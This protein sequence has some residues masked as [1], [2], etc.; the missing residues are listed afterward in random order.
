MGIR[1]ASMQYVARRL[2][3]LLLLAFSV[4]WQPCSAELADG[5]AELCLSCH[6]YPGL[7]RQ[8]ENNT[9]KI[10][11][12]D[13]DK[14]RASS[15]GQLACRECHLGV[16]QIP[17][18][19]Q[20]RTDC[21]SQCHQQ[22][23]ALLDA[24]PRKAFHKGQ[25]S[26]VVSLEDQTS[27]KVCHQIYP[28]KKE[29]FLRAFL[30]MH[31]GYL[32]CEVCHLK[33][34]DFGVVRY[35]WVESTDVVFEGEPIGSVYDPQRRTVQQAQSSLSRISPFV[36]RQGQS[37]A[38]MNTWDT[39]GA[40][41]LCSAR[42][43]LDADDKALGLG[44]YHRDVVK[45]ERTTVCEECHTKNGFLDFQAL[46]FSRGRSETLQSMPIGNIIKKYDVFYMPKLGKL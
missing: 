29:P 44:Y 4:S 34:S 30:N 35:D 3:V 1:C 37:Q 10:L 46:G 21:N 8:D 17:H 33:R 38:L 28:H 22:D 43:T 14:F 42:A 45:M 26:A 12:I 36:V 9:L 32:A 13:E 6:Q 31:T 19:G 18:V 11:H 7:V 41:K 16:S 15:H 27:C 2:A 23:Q 39:D 5:E 25:Q 24:T 40:Q 20:N